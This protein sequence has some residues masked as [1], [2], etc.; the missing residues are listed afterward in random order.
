M[1]MRR[2]KNVM[3]IKECTAL[4]KAKE[5]E[6]LYKHDNE[7]IRYQTLYNPETKEAADR[8]PKYYVTQNQASLGNI[9]QRDEG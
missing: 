6:K 1:A 8:P 9:I 7:R 2:N 5:I 4:V 3:C